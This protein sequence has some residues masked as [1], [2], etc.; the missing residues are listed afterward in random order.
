MRRL[1]RLNR[2]QAL[3][4]LTQLSMNLNQSKAAIGAG[5]AGMGTAALPSIGL[6]GSEAANLST[7]QHQSNNQKSVSQGNLQAQS[8]LNQGSMYGSIVGGLAS[9]AS[10]ALGVVGSNGWLNN[11]FQGSSTNP[12]APGGALP[13]NVNYGNQGVVSGLNLTP[14]ITN[15]VGP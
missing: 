9:G 13:G 6:T 10:G 8:A 4:E 3:N 2:R 7:R 1:Y 12:A 15:S 5:A 14:G 11:L